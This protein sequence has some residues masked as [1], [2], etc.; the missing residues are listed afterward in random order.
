MTKH[1]HLLHLRRDG[2]GRVNPP[3][4]F[5][6]FLP[7]IEGKPGHKASGFWEARNPG[8]VA[9]LVGGLAYI[10]T[11]TVLGQ[12]PAPS[13][14]VYRITEIIDV[15]DLRMPEYEFVLL[16]VQRGAP[17]YNGTFGLILAPVQGISQVRSWRGPWP[18]H[19]ERTTHNSI[20]D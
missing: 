4:Q 14:F 9:K 10:H 17:M 15:W 11:R 2:N 12:G 16:G 13:E 20:V 6:A 19:I 7:D 8:D 3:G 1:I 18:V 5:V